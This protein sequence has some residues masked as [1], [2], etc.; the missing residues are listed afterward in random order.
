MASIDKDDL[1]K[2]ATPQTVELLMG[3]REF[4]VCGGHDVSGVVK[5]GGKLIAVSST[6]NPKD[7]TSGLTCLVALPP[8]V[9]KD[10]FLISVFGY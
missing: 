10:G 8:G 5:A 1:L 9:T 7:G 6:D 2:L 3:M 4:A